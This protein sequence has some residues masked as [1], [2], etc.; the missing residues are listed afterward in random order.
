MGKL[1]VLVMQDV[2]VQLLI[3]VYLRST[4]CSP[5]VQFYSTARCRPVTWP[6]PPPP[7]CPQIGYE[8]AASVLN[9]LGPYVSHA[10]VCGRQFVHTVLLELLAFRYFAPKIPFLC[11]W[12]VILVILNFWPERQSLSRH[13]HC[14]SNHLVNE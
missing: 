13:W 10:S 5:M 8:A 2:E 12:R 4:A 6:C 7:L 11:L 1:S 14:S 9:F 3:Y